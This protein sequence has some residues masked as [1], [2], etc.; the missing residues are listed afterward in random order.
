MPNRIKDPVNY[1][2]D[3]TEPTSEVGFKDFLKKMTDVP[4]S[5]AL[6]NI[7]IN[8]AGITNQQVY[9]TIDDLSDPKTKTPVLC[10][11]TLAVDLSDHRGI[12]MS[13]CEEA[14]F[15]ISKG[16]YSDLDQFA[17][18][19]AERLREKQASNLGIVKISGIHL[20]HRQTRKTARSSHDKVVLLSEAIASKSDPIQKTGVTAFNMTACPCTKTYT[21]LSVI[22]RLKEMGFDTEQ[23]NK[24][25]EIVLTGTHT[26]RGAITVIMDKKHPEISAREILGVLDE[27]TH[28]VNELLKRPDEHDLVIRA[29]QKPQFTED[30]IRDVA[31]G[32]FERFGSVAPPDTRVIV[33]SILNDSIHIH[34]VRT[35]ITATL[36]GI[37]NALKR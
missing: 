18:A 19:L 1:T 12:H 6:N 28:L 27:T 33:E 37:K 26:Q 7:P 20:H 10:D 3:G 5:E 23:I 22:P 14:L 11:V 15:E 29:L 21:K 13:R 31:Q 8:E 32:L 4:E 36:G 2:L 16:T 24:I 34:D 17:L 25:L 30:V 35:K 9:V